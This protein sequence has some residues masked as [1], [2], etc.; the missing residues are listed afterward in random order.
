MEPFLGEHFGN[1]SSTHRVGRHAAKAVRQARR[2]V[3]DRFGV[4]SSAVSFASGATEA[5]NQA[6]LGTA[7]AAEHA[8]PHLVVTAVEHPAVLAP[9]YW[10][11]DTGRAS[12]T[13][14]G[15]HASGRISLDEVQAA[16]RPETVLVAT[17]LVNN[18]TGVRSATM[19]IANTARSVHSDLCV[20]VDA[21]QA[22]AR[23]PF[24]LSETGADLLVISGHKMGG[25]Q[26]IG[27]LLCGTEMHT[28]P[29]LLRGG[30]QE[31]GR[32]GGTENVAGIVGLGAACELRV[33]TEEM[34]RLDHRLLAG[35]REHIDG[36]TLHGEGAARVPGTLNMRVHGV[37]A[38][39]LL[40]HLEL[41]SVMASSG[42][43]CSSGTRDPSHVLKAMGVDPVSI[44]ESV[45]LSLGRTTTQDEVDRLIEVLPKI[46]RELRS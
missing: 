4:K 31:Q 1:P 25:P 10:L 45:R 26:G 43:A 19:K 27:A 37:E 28:A 36:L 6:I 35:L 41:A 46:V 12:L 15:V 16:I 5:L 8:R 29:T 11:R 34:A 14:V 20:L 21:V 33:D 39:T 18:E 7:L 44:H 9:C 22:T 30:N 38:E 2:Q 23:F 42:S 40:L 13:V 32:R 17:M 24:Q 3:A